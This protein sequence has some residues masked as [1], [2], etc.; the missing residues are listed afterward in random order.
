M[1]GNQNLCQM[2]GEDSIKSED[3]SQPNKTQKI[4]MA[5]KGFR[6]F[7]ELEASKSSELRSVQ[8]EVLNRLKTAVFR[9]FKSLMAPRGFEPPT[10][11][12]KGRCSK[13]G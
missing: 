11:G 1:T 6:Q 2:H 7:I 5:S 13:P 10:P 4:V 8:H 3:N 12:L 9:M